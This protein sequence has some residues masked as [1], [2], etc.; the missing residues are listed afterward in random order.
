MN[1]PVP[2]TDPTEP[3]ADAA[4]VTLLA[5]C[6]DAL[7]SGVVPPPGAAADDVALLQ[8]LDQLRPPVPAV[9]PRPEG[10]PPTQPPDGDP[11]YVLRGLHAEGGIGRVWLAYDS[12]LGRDVALKVLRPDR[13][14]DPRLAAR[15]VHEAQVTGRLQHPGIVPVYELAP[16]AAAGGPADDDPPFYTMRLVQGRTLTEAIAAYHARR[17]A[18][19]ASPVERATLLNAFVS[20]CHTVA[21]AH[22]KGVVHRDLKPENVVLGDYGEVV[23]LDWGFAKELAAADEATEDGR[24]SATTPDAGRPA[25]HHSVAG[26]VLGTPAYMAPEQA[27]G[28]P[29]DERSDVYGLGAI[30]YE[31]LTGRPPYAGD[32]SADVLRQVRAAPPARPRAVAPRLPPA[33]EAV[34]LTA[35]A[36]DPADRYQSA[37]AL[38]SDVQHWLADEPVSAYPEPAAARLRRWAR[39]HRPLVAFGTALLLTG[40]LAAIGLM[41]VIQQEETRSADERARTAMEHAAAMGRAGAALEHQL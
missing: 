34:C 23:V 11:R 16:G 5:A 10:A 22:S 35:L 26:Q 36:R 19:R 31:L 7:A 12:D 1:S 39:R 17:A 32:D 14:A 37:A 9:S 4:R 13:V 20:V 6:D 25:P 30:L 38:A 29:V 40:L 2:T 24:L 3:P 27:A 18:R 41:V 8:L 15:F 33:L 21:Y 28:E